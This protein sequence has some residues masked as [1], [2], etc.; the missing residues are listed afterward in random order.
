LKVSANVKIAIEYFEIFGGANS[1]N[2]S[3][4][5]LRQVVRKSAT[6]EQ[7]FSLRIFDTQI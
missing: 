4:G 3:A 6:A 5:S 7:T 2:A 1:S